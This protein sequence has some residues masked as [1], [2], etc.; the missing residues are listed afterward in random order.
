MCVSAK[1]NS[2]GDDTARSRLNVPGGPVATDLPLEPCPSR[3]VNGANARLD[4]SARIIRMENKYEAE[5]IV[6]TVAVAG[7]AFVGDGTDRK[8]INDIAY[9]YASG[10]VRTYPPDGFA[11]GNGNGRET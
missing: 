10:R 5:R 1:V 3:P 8:S 2:N 9:S 4:L 11:P 6:D 7:S